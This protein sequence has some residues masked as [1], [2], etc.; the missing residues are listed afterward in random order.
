MTEQ[1]INDGK[2]E[3]ARLNQ[4]QMDLRDEMLKHQ[5]LAEEAKSKRDKVKKAYGAL[6]EEVGKAHRALHPRPVAPP[7]APRVRVEKEPKQGWW[8][9]L[10][11]G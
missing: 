3:L 10:F 1:E 7:P 8:K 4:L 11:G 9:R 2:Q 5:K 6:Y